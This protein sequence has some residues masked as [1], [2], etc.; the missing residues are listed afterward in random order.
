MSKCCMD[1]CATV[2]TNELR[3]MR[4][5]RSINAT[6]AQYCLKA[7]HQWCGLEQEVKKMVR[8]CWFVRGV[9]A[10]VSLMEK[11]QNL[12]TSQAV[13]VRD[14]D[15]SV[16]LTWCNARRSFRASW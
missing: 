16:A 15:R 2:M 9:G 7:L 5:R 4:A 12:E 3:Y 14:A 1:G 11:V 13:H 10:K 8:L 6:G